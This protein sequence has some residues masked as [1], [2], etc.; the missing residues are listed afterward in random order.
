LDS[1]SEDTAPKG[2]QGPQCCVILLE[3]RAKEFKAV[4][5]IAHSESKYPASSAR[6][7]GEPSSWAVSH[8]LKTRSQSDLNASR[9]Q[10]SIRTVKARHPYWSNHWGDLRLGMIGHSSLAIAGSHRS[11]P[12]FS[13]TRGEHV[14][15]PPIWWSGAERPHHLVKLRRACCRRRWELVARVKRASRGG[16][17]PYSR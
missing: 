16:N 6:D 11:E 8:C 9:V 2:P 14:V 3:A 17:D 10:P 4:A 13:L 15:E 1:D 12:Q 5:S 7:P